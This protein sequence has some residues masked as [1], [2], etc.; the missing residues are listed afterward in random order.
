MSDSQP[1]CAAGN[2]ASSRPGSRRLGSAF[3]VAWVL[4]TLLRVGLAFVLPTQGMEDLRI[5]QHIAAGDGFTADPLRGPSALKA[6]L[7][8]A[9]LALLWRIAPHPRFLA[10]CQHLLFAAS[11]LRLRQVLRR[12]D[13]GRA[14]EVAA[15]MFLL[16][17]S[18]LV[19]P[20]R[21]EATNLLVPLLVLLLGTYL[22]SRSGST[23]SRAALGTIGGA[24]VL[25]Q[26]VALPSVLWLLV[27]G[28]RRCRIRRLLPALLL[29]ALPVG[30]WTV[31]NAVVLDRWIPLKA[32]FWMNVWQG[33]LP[34]YAVAPRYAVVSAGERARVDSLRAVRSEPDMETEYRQLVLARIRRDPLAF[35][36]RTAVQ[37]LTYWFVPPRLLRERPASSLCLRVVP[38]V[39]L[40]LLL[41]PG[42]V[43]LRRRCPPLASATLAFLIPF[44]VVYGL[45]QISNTR[46][47]LDVEWLTLLP[48]AMVLAPPRGRPG[49]EREG[50]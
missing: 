4:V 38:V 36:E 8:P 11:A 2:S 6:P 32:A 20:N 34:E 12:A 49:P 18:Y 37:M 24:A 50:T 27:S 25:T 41:I 47:K 42:L 40:N 3:A 5:A 19:Y 13:L 39:L 28:P 9:I 48:A 31:R 10:L 17:P 15:W 23:R 14:G 33:D 30:A 26:P 1:E 45:T 46:F 16:H 21:F 35:V 7:Y 43:R 22:S 44:T 29:F